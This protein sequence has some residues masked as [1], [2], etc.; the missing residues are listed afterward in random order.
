MLDP[1]LIPF[2][3]TYLASYQAGPFIYLILALLFSFGGFFVWK[4]WQADGR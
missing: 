1:R 4:R 3:G 2:F